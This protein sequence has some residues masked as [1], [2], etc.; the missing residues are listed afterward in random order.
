MRKLHLIILLNFAIVFN[1]FAQNYY[2]GFTLYAP[3]NSTTAY[4]IDMNNSTVHTWS[5]NHTPAEKVYLLENGHLLATG[6]DPS[7]QLN[8]GAVGGYIEEYDWDGNLVWQ[9][10]Y[11]SS[12]YCLHHDICPMPNGN[13]LAIAW[14][15]KTA[16]EAQAMG[17]STYSE[18]WPLHIIEIEKTGT[19][20]G[21]IVWEWHLWDHL[22]QD[23]DSSKPNYGV[24]A[25]HPELMDI[26]NIDG[27]GSK[28]P[29]TGGDWLHTNHIDYNDSLDQI[30]FSSHTLMEV[31]II[32]HSTT[33]AEAAGHSGGNSGKGGD[34]LYRWGNP[35]GY[36]QGTSADQVFYVVHGGH[37]IDYDLPGGGDL[38][39]FNNGIWSSR[40]K[41]IIS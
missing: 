17:S 3:G 35:Q 22:I 20:S 34:F 13:L 14:E 7:A 39:A 41:F 6:R 11:S 37:W 26:N 30:C 5:L 33:T 25:D 12:T 38:M 24:V 23:Y 9:Y 18:R 19:Y 15:V 16:A 27:T 21:N 36:D 29:P 40:W 10:H 28:P 31:Y 8:G 2:K 1:T 32:D 4:L